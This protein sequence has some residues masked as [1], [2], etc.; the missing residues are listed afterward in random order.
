MSQLSISRP[1]GRA[2]GK[3]NAPAKPAAEK[4]RNVGPKSAAW[5]RQVGIKTTEDV[6]ALGAFSAFL[7]VRKAGF[8]ASLSLIYALAAAEDDC[9]WQALTLE[10]KA[11]LLE[12]YNEFEAN[13][14][15]AK[16]IFT[17]RH[18]GPSLGATLV[19]Q[20]LGKSDDVPQD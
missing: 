8:K 17:P 7:K 2:I 16:K 11:P 6:R 13:A 3:S 10:R 5:L 18:G 9:H 20:A 12:L 1:T 14:K 19:E 15:A 4:I